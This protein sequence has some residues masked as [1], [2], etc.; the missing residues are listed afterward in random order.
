MT[1]RIHLQQT[2]RKMAQ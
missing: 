2:R 1:D